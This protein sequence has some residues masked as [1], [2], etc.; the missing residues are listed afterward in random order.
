MVEISEKAIEKLLEIQQQDDEG[1]P[2]RI[3]L[4]SGSSTGPNLGVLC[5]S[6]AETDQSFSY[7]ELEV[8]VDEKLLTYCQKISIEFV[9]NDVSACSADGGFKISPQVSI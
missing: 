9:Q 6:R 1:K 2:V 3:G 5:D 8:I 4:V 7:G